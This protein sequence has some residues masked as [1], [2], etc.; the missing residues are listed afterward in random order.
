MATEMTFR[1]LGDSGPEKIKKILTIGDE[2]LERTS[3][4]SAF[5]SYVERAP[6]NTDC[7]N[8]WRY[9]QKPH[10]PS[11]PNFT[12]H[13]NMDDLASIVTELNDSISNQKL[14]G[15]WPYHFGF[16]V[17]LTTFLESYD[18]LHNVEYF[19]SEFPDGDDSGR[20]YPIKFKGQTT[21]LADFWESG[22]GRYTRKVP[23]TAEQWKEIDKAVTEEFAKN[24]Q[25][26]L[27]ITK[28]LLTAQMESYNISVDYV[29]EG[30]SKNGV[31]SDE[32][33]DKCVKI[34]SVRFAT[35]AYS[36][37]SFLK[38]LKIPVIQK[39]AASAPLRT[40]EAIGWSVTCMLL[41]LTLYLVWNYFKTKTK[42]LSY[43]KYLLFRGHF[44]NT[45]L[46]SFIPL[47]I[48]FTLVDHIEKFF[49][50]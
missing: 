12:A 32:Y 1:Y 46:H 15:P 34:T 23:F 35:A 14:N 45:F 43:N 9:T 29:Y 11:F 25:S 33:Y 47:R 8:H 36:L 13:S 18:P 7:F 37:G 31:V 44:Q 10:A 39:N 50:L 5:L 28:D 49:C 48:N 26:S 22:C 27:I 41:P 38:S 40:S 16:K 4:A 42:L 21:T 2:E 24:P 30:I 3:L 20:N 17:F 19:S 6:Y